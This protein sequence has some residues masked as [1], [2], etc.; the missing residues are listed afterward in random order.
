[1]AWTEALTTWRRDPTRANHLALSNALRAEKFCGASDP[2]ILEWALALPGPF[3]DPSTMKHLALEAV[4]MAADRTVAIDAR[5]G[6]LQSGT[7]RA[8]DRVIRALLCKAASTRSLQFVAALELALAC[9]REAR[10][11]LSAY[12]RIDRK[13]FPA[14]ETADVE[15]QSVG[16][17]GPVE[18]LCDR[19]GLDAVPDL[20]DHVLGSDLPAPD[21][22]P[23]VFEQFPVVLREWRK[24]PVAQAFKAF[25]E[26][27]RARGLRVTGSA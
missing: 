11:H 27:N 3:E 1:V 15:V 13:V 12:C 16:I 8:R 14:V 25:D 17:L 9:P 20:E 2:A 24:V 6:A 7:S 18:Y 26:T 23:T 21:A 19:G 4:I 22:A 5:I 10:H